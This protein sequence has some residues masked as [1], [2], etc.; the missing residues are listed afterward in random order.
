MGDVVYLAIIASEGAGNDVWRVTLV[1]T[2]I[3]AAA[4]AA[5]VGSVVAD[6]RI[7]CALLSAAA[8]A[9]MSLGT[10]ALLSIGILFLVAGVLATVAT[11][12]EI[13]RDPR[14]G[15]ALV[16]AVVG[17]TLVLGPFLLTA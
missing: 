2:T 12:T 5:W 8:A 10:L 9:L 15:A 3:G 14:P 17:F 6:A 4:S 16:G 13:V 7:R 1:A 11:S